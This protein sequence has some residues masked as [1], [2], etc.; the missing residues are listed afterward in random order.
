MAAWRISVLVLLLCVAQP[1]F[2]RGSKVVLQAPKAVRAL[3]DEHFVLPDTVLREDSERAAFMRRARREIPE[4]LAT[5][6]FFSA[7]VKLSK[8][9]RAGVLEVEVDSGPRTRV[10]A[11]EIELRGDL[12]SDPAR[13]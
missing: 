6:G 10:S 1:A 3:L 5:E 4:L 9:T 12:Q 8:I 7:S 2:A 11:V 13:A